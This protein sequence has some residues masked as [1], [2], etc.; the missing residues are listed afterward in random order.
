M[1]CCPA[2]FLPDSCG[3]DKEVRRLRV[4][5]DCAVSHNGDIPMTGTQEFKEKCPDDSDTIIFVRDYATKLFNNTEELKDEARLKI[6][7]ALIGTSKM[8]LHTK[9][10]ISIVGVF[11]E[12]KGIYYSNFS[13]EVRFDDFTEIT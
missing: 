2:E 3:D 13:N 8:A 5:T 11:N 12:R 1:A 9:D 10:G 7:S 6:L 4:T